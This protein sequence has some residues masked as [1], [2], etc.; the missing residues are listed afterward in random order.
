MDH[1]QRLLEPLLSLGATWSF[2]RHKRFHLGKEAHVF[3]VI[4]WR[5]LIAITEIKPLGI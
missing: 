2:L 3:G 5:R 4:F 1:S